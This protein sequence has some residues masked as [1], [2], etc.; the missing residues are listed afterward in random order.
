MMYIMILYKCKIHQVF[1]KKKIFLRFSDIRLVGIVK[2]FDSKLAR[3]KKHNK[4]K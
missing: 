2:L 1:I 3:S 4:F